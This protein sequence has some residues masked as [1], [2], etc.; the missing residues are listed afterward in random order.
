MLTCIIDVFKKRY[1]ATV[2]IP[3][4]FLRTKISQGEDNV[5]VLLDGKMAEFL[6]KIASKN[7]KNPSIRDKDRHT[8]GAV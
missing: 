8:Y 5:H 1:I 4:V 6:A 3:G 2:D 7:I